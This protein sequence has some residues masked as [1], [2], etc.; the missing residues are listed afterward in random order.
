L[1]KVEELDRKRH[2]RETFDCGSEPLNRFIKTHAAKQ[3]E[4]GVSRTFVLVETSNAVPRPILGY[5][6]LAVS[7]IQS[8]ELPK[9]C[10]KG[11]LPQTVGVLLLGRLAV[12]REFHR[13]GLG[14]FLLADVFKRFTEVSTAV[15]GV[16]LLVDAKDEKA[17]EYYLAT[18]FT[19]LEP[20]P[21]RLFLGKN[22]IEATIRAATEQ[23]LEE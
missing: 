10:R 20:S 19:R 14:K 8:G 1:H 21:M 2:V 11:G 9:T 22:T 17:A 13:G 12:A 23:I 18:G 4:Q 16:G 5:Y 7:Q 15:G 3:A 6:T